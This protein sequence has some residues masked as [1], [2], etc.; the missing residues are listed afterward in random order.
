MEGHGRS[1]KAIEG[2]GRSWKVMEGLK[3]YFDLVLDGAVGELQLELVHVVWHKELVVGEV[4]LA[5]EKNY[6]IF[7]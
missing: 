4:F 6:D 5:A 7:I 1:W 2:H 3:T